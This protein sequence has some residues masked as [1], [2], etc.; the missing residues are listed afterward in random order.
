MF[1][2]LVH[3]WK[4]ERGL[5]PREVAQKVKLFFHYYCKKPNAVMP[6]LRLTGDGRHQPPQDD[7]HDPG[8]PHGKVRLDSQ[9]GASAKF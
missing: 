9:R 4:D 7:D 6:G 8:S 5:G 1:Q 2:K 3:D